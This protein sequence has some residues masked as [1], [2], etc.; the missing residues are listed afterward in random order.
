MRPGRFVEIP[1]HHHD[2]MRGVFDPA[3]TPVVSE[4]VLGEGLASPRPCLPLAVVVS[5]QACLCCT[6]AFKAVA[7]LSRMSSISRKAPRFAR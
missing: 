3:H 5:S 1:V 2:E 7:L 6:V 4:F